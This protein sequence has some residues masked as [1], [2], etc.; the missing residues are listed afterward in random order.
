MAH[1]LPAVPISPRNT[2]V[3]TT[4]AQGEPLSKSALKKLRKEWEK[5]KAFYEKFNS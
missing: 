2:G 3:P 4:D 5:Q 1:V